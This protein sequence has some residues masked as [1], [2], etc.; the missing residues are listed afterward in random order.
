MGTENRQ[1]KDAIYD[2]FARIGKALSSPKRLELLDLLCQGPKKVETLARESQMSIANTSRHLQLLLGSRLVTNQKDGVSVYYK[3]ADDAVCDFILAFR[4]LAEQ[5]LAEVE[6]ITR[7]FLEQKGQFEPVDQDQLL[8]RVQQGEVTVLDV[9]PEDEYRTG[10]LPGA[11]S[12]PLPDLKSRLKDLP[13]D[14]EIV[15]YCRG[16]YC[17]LAVEAVNLLRKEGFQAI[18]LE[19]GVPDWKARGL[20]L[21]ADNTGGQ[22]NDS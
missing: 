3:L 1:F 5:R 11:L 18:R 9:R 8:A 7:Q 16:P 17:V 20:S 19:E 10:H 14:Q 2:Q 13:R 15:A 12:V 4:H 6:S 21:E 22:S